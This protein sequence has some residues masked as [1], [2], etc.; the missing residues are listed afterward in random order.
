ME[1]GWRLMESSAEMRRKLSTRN[2]NGAWIEWRN[3]KEIEQWSLKGIQESAS[4]SNGKQNSAE[5]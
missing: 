5:N 1:L 4:S 3:Q 2:S